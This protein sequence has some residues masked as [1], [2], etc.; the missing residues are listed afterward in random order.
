MEEK[1]PKFKLPTLYIPH[2]GGPCFFMDWRMGSADTWN[3]MEAW[4]RQLSATIGSRPKAILVISAHWETPVVS[5][6]SDPNPPLLYDYFGFPEHTYHLKYDAP[7]SPEVARR[8]IRLLEEAHIPC[9]EETKRGWDHGVFVPLKL[10][11]PDADVP[12]VSLS[13]KAGL[14]PQAHI[15]MG[16][17]LQPLREEGILIIGSGMSYHNM[18]GSSH[19]RGTEFSKQFNDWLVESCEKEP[20]IRNTRLIDWS[21]APAARHSHPREEHLLPLMVCAGAAGEDR[22]TVI[23][24][25]QVMTIWTTGIQFGSSLPEG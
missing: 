3:S 17:A 9:V 14:D 7:G 25:E 19:P 24:Q 20:E 12:V 21:Q 15:E 10:I 2:G 5:V 18:E 13:L 16:K 8:I 22:G 6:T 4:L 11:Y 23:F 1:T